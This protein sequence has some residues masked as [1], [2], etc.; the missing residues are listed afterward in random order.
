MNRATLRTMLLATVA[1]LAMGCGVSEHS[2]GNVQSA[3]VAARTPARKPSVQK[4]VNTKRLPADRLV[5][6][7]ERAGLET[8]AMGPAEIHVDDTSRFPEEP[9]SSMVL[10]VSDR[11]GNSTPMTFVEF[12]SW[13]AA[14]ELDRK[15]VNGFA[16][17][18][19]FVLGTTSTYFVEL[20]TDALAG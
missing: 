11:K 19:W 10:R 13:K 3:R 7:L 20:V 4:P 17:R 16:V 8:Q 9:L 15:P 1:V 6:A 5:A 12:D 18:N 14:A 2:D